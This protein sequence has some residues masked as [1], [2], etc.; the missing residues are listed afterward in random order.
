MVY[1]STHQPTNEEILRK[2]QNAGYIDSDTAAELAAE[3][4]EDVL[5]AIYGYILLNDDD[6]DKV[7]QVW[8]IV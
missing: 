8:G 2:A 6:P 4:Q 7:F 5:S 3:D 1:I